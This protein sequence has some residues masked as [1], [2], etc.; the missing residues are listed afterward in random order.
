M[1]GDQVGA[2]EYAKMLD[3]FMKTN[4]FKDYVKFGGKAKAIESIRDKMKKVDL[5]TRESLEDMMLELRREMV[6]EMEKAN[7]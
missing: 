6:E 2:M 7:D 3:D 4:L 1:K 5:Q